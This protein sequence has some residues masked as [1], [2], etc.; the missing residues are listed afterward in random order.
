MYLPSDFLATMLCEYTRLKGA[1]PTIGALTSNHSQYDGTKNPDIYPG[2]LDP[3]GFVGPNPRRDLGG[4]FIPGCPFFIPRSLFLQSNGFCEQIFLYGDDIDLSWRLVLM[5]RKNY[6]T[7]ATTLYHA[8]G[9]SMKGFPPKKIYYLLH[10]VP[11]AMFN[12]TAWPLFVVLLSLHLL[13]VLLVIHPGFLLFTRGDLRYNAASIEAIADFFRKIPQ[14]RAW[15][16]QVQRL[17]TVN[18]I[19]FLK[20]HMTIFPALLR[21]RPYRRL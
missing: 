6:A 8:E 17:R 1:D 3:L 11:I 19:D 7:H 18:D 12:N 21:T 16:Q 4:A 14:L 2:V 15:R 9:G 13:F 5:G 10:T 20:Q